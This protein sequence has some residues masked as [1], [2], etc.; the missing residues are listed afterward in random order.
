MATTVEAGRRKPFLVSFFDEL[1]LYSGQY[2][3][4]YVLMNFTRDGVGFFSD[5]GHAALLA[6]LAAQTA[7]LAL[8]GDAPIPRFVLSLIAPAIYVLKES[9]EGADFFQDMSH[10]FFWT[11]SIAVAALQAAARTGKPR[12][13]R[14]A[15]E[16]LV[17]ILNVAAFFAVYVYFDYRLTL[18]ASGADAAAIGEALSIF[19]AADG[20]ADFIA[21]KSH[22]YTLVGGA[23][24][25]VT[26]AVGRIRILDLKERL[27]ELFGQ[28]VDPSF[29]DRIVGE[30]GGVPRMREL[31]V[32]FSDIRSFT[33]LSEREAPERISGMLNGYFTEWEESITR[34][35]GIVDKYIGD[36][37][38]AIFAPDGGAA[39]CERAAECAL[40]MLNGLPGLRARLA[41]SGLPAPEA[42]GVG[43]D[44]GPVI[45]GDLGSR[46]RK[47]YTVLGDHVN[48]ASRMESFCKEAG[49]PC[50]ISEAVFSRLDES[51]A[52]RF[53]ALGGVLVKGKSEQVRIYGIRIGKQAAP[54]SS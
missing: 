42:I 48:T 19:R 13:F 17:T 12:R 52:E 41:E 23:F 5:A 31:C 15:V 49:R 36:A 28:Y 26:I 22:V 47:N 16:F 9:Y 51:T 38:M 25:A 14:M 44:F 29:R 32:L 33:A 43:I 11:F 18:E 46:R 21:D 39:P 45:M 50:I 6:A 4:F 8:W 35:G 53:E 54:E 2:A 3:L 1:L 27:H 7:A 10:A 40:E 24:L 37:V 30:N 34:H 20:F